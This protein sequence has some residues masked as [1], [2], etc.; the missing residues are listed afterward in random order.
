MQDAS[1]AEAVGQRF[2]HVL[3]DEMQDTN[4]LQYLII[5]ALAPHTS[6][7][8]VGDDAQSIYG[9]RGADFASIHS[10]TDRYP[11]AQVY[12]LQQ[13]YRSTQEIL[14]LSNWLLGQSP[15]NYDK[16]LTAA[17]GTGD[18]PK[19]IER[20]D[21]HQQADYIARTIL[22]AYDCEERWSNNMVL[23]RTGYSGRSIESKFLEYKIPHVLI[24][25]VSLFGAKHV[26]DV[27]SLLR[28][29]A[30]RQDEIAWM[31]Y[32]QLW[33]RIGDR[34]AD[35][36]F[37]ALAF[38]DTAVDQPANTLMQAVQQFA[39]SDQ[40]GWTG[41]LIYC[42]QGSTAPATAFRCAVEALTPRLS[43]LYQNDHW[44]T[45]QKDFEYVGQ[46][47]ERHRTIAGFVDE[48]LLN[49]VYESEL[50]RSAGDDKVKII[51][52]H[53]AKGLEAPRCFVTDVQPGVY[54][55]AGLTEA[56]IE[57][58]RRVL[59]VAMTRA[60]N[61]L[62]VCRCQRGWASSYVGQGDEGY[63]L[64]GLRGGLVQ[65]D[66]LPPRVSRGSR[67]GRRGSVDQVLRASSAT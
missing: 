60:A 5:D 33:P 58:E 46:L 30:N 17:R 64:D 22:T 51:T 2:S 48:Y 7:F 41:P 52:I 6:L 61:E 8:C 44:E 35:R 37:Q 4:P 18:V 19:L 32:L 65:Q 20:E 3:I 59:Y 43:T 34:T 25:G 31:R 49:P 66:R 23:V 28:I 9:F 63:F 15:L 16:S 29:L 26:K 62:H 45:R 24:G 38:G 36:L 47:A 67:S 12:R 40:S 10:F 21:Q 53:S 55:K 39:A 11:T 1:L 13:N 56:E 54:P 14:D 50:R 27:V 57:E 42:L